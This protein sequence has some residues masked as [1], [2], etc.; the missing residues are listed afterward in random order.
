MMSNNKPIILLFS[1]AWSTKLI[2]KHQIDLLK[3]HYQIVEP[4]IHQLSSIYE[5]SDM[6]IKQYSEQNIAAVIGLSMGGYIV[7]DLLIKARD[8]CQKAI[9]LGSS[10]LPLA[11]T[12]KNFIS[13][14]ITEIE[15]GQDPIH[16]VNFYAQSVLLPN[17]ASDPAMQTLLKTALHELGPAGC[18][19]HHKACIGW[20]G[21]DQAM[22]RKLKNVALLVIAGKEDSAVN[23]KET[24][25]IAKNVPNATFALIENAAHFSMLE[26]PEQANGLIMNFLRSNS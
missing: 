2:F 22:L 3:Q 23:Y 12:V 18:I 11:N 1:A 15:N 19:N 6:V 10:S 8:F 26:Q 24:Q 20:Q 13:E 16:Y 4:D 14:M 25:L 7:L 9:I 17:N 21:Y 5:M